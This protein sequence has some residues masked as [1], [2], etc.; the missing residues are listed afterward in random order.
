MQSRATIEIVQTIL[1]AGIGFEMPLL[2]NVP[3]L[4]GEAATTSRVPSHVAQRREP[5]SY[6]TWGQGGPLSA[7]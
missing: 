6:A 3:I 4:T 1:D 5:R 2:E 7:V